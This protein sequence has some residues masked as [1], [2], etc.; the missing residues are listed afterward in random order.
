MNEIYGGITV[1]TAKNRERDSY[2]FANINLLGRCNARCFFCLGEDLPNQLGCYKN[3][4][5]MRTRFDKW[6]R[7]D[8]FKS[9]CKKEGITKLYV[10]GQ[11]TDSLLYPYL[12]QLVDHLQRDGF[13]VGLRTNGYELMEFPELIGDV[14]NR[15]DLSVGYSIH[16][17]NPIA[18]KM[19]LGRKDVPTWDWILSKTERPRVSIVLNRCNEH[20]FFEI[21]R[22]LAH[23]KDHVRYVQVRRVSTDT[24]QKLLMPDMVAYERQYSKV[25]EIFPLVK[26]FATDA[27][28]YKIYGM[29][30][31]FWRT[32][33]TSV[34][35][36][37][38]FIDGTISD[39]YFVVEGYLK[40]SQRGE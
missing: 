25:R 14:I 13:Q 37:N 2:S 5:L 28:V 8:E 15:T 33:K 17:L 19:I 10:T 7:W 1:N 22:Y 20:E 36:L 23:F 32:V 11:N 9:R 29:D 30:V 38:Y 12:C 6:S 39:L 27:E 26:T 18:N 21:L 34:N 16:S 3:N 40:Y 35:S 4:A 24:R 31:V